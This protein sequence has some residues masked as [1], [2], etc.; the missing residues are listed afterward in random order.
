MSL[1][2]PDA[3]KSITCRIL[4]LCMTFL[5]RNLLSLSLLLGILEPG[6]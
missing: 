3:A 2:R 5:C 1:S 6:M 4:K